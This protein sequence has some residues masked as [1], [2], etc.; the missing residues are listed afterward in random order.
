M[1][2]AGRTE[3]TFTGALE[4]LQDDGHGRDLL[5][6]FFF[7][8]I[9]LG[10]PLRR[11]LQNAVRGAAAASETA[12]PAFLERTR[13]AAMACRTTLSSTQEQRKKKAN[14]LKNSS[15]D[16]GVP[17]RDSWPSHHDFEANRDAPRRSAKQKEKDDV[18]KLLDKKPK[19]ARK[20]KA[21]EKAPLGALK[22]T[23]KKS[24]LA[25][26][27]AASPVAKKE[28]THTGDHLGE[29]KKEPTRTGGDEADRPPSRTAWKSNARWRGRI[30]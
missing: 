28:P 5:L 16:L 11:I 22:T 3:S 20:K 14:D 26:I 6:Q 29:V 18:R 10:P 19:K 1:D 23:D 2:R 15:C 21:L 27:K 9:D 25:P 7:G 24:D 8:G 4:A 13:V 17:R 30:P 12:R